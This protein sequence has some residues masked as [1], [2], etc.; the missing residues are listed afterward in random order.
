MRK[1]KNSDEILW[2]EAKTYL[3]TSDKTQLERLCN[4]LEATKSEILRLALRRLFNA[5]VIGIAETE[6]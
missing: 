3:N 5:E 6:A 1:P 4:L 2:Y